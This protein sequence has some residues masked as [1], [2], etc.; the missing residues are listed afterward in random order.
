MQFNTALGF[1]LA[2]ISILMVY[3]NQC[4]KA[5]ICTA[6]VGL[7]GFIT[8]LEYLFSINLFL[9]ELFMKHYI[10]L[11]TSNPGRMA[12]NTA[13]CFTLTA[14]SI[15]YINTRSRINISSLIGSL[16]F[17]L[18]LTAFVGY[19]I[20]TDLTYAWGY[21]TQMAIHTAFGF[22]F[23]GIGVSFLSWKATNRILGQSKTSSLLGYLIAIPI[24]IL[25][26][27]IN[28]PLGIGVGT[29]YV[30]L[31]L[32]GWFIDLQKITIYLALVATLLILIGYKNSP[33]GNQEWMAIINRSLSIISVWIVAILLYNIKKNSNLFRKNT[34]DYTK[35]LELKNKELEQFVYISSHDLQEP[36]KVI[37][38][39][40]SLLELEHQ[41]KLDDEANFYIASIKQSC[42]KMSSLINGLLNYGRIG[43]N[44]ER[45]LVDCNQ[46]LNDVTESITPL[47]KEKNAE[48]I[49]KKLPRL[50]ANQ[51]DLFLLFQNLITNAIKFQAPNTIPKIKID[52]KE[53]L[54][55]WRISVED[56]G[57]GI[58][59]EHLNKIFL[60][61][62]R[63]H[64]VDEYEGI[65]VG[66]AQCSKIVEQHNG[67]IWA[68]STPQKG[69]VFHFTLKK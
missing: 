24:T 41:K 46:I 68:T 21:F 15:F 52:S 50:H 54:S 61:F 27:D 9:D 55:H 2:G 10:T 23:I 53:E 22:M 26:I 4:T 1:T 56:N 34:E 32:L 49:V 16:I 12:P 39:F 67:Q 51:N 47:I 11:K 65:G 14:L 58:E 29:L 48:L 17:G 57:I 38:S 45:T 43:A 6:L 59:K 20:N 7:I 13:L 44:H 40:T 33:T 63:L 37:S 8:L 60:I 28:S 62:K 35:T 66:L 42:T 25:L 18:G 19:Y 30:I 31:V 69:S 36:L 3:F 5:R 64:N